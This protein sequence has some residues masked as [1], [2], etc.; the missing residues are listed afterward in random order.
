MS[1][2][3]YLHGS[4]VIPAKEWPKLKK[5]IFTAWNKKRDAMQDIGN[6]IYEQYKGK[7]LATMREKH[8]VDILNLARSFTGSYSRICG[9]DEYDLLNIVY[10]TSAKKVGKP[11]ALSMDKMMAKAKTTTTTL[12]E[13]YSEFSIELDNKTRTLSIRIEENNRNVNDFFEMTDQYKTSLLQAIKNVD[14]GRNSGGSMT[15][16][17]ETH[18]SESEGR[19]DKTY[20]CEYGPIAKKEQDLRHKIIKMQIKS[21][22]GK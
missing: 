11:T 17:S 5:A 2:N 4:Y 19:Y 7:S 10:I 12:Q 9:Y 1:T 21:L 18:D 22:R 6:S 20:L 3:Q 13:R 14:W 8:A 15:E 16:Y